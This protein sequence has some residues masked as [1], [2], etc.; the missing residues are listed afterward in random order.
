M[1][2]AMN[3]TRFCRTG[4]GRLL[5][6]SVAGTALAALW[7]GGLDTARAQSFINMDF[8]QAGESTI[9]SNA[10]WLDWNIGAPG[11]AHAGA[12]DSVF[13]YHYTPSTSV[14]QYYF[15]ADQYSTSWQPLNGNYSLVLLSGHYSPTD[16]TSPWINA[17]IAQTAMIPAGT[18]SFTMLATGNF[19]VSIGSTTLQM[20]NLGS[21][22][23]GAD[24][25]QFAGQTQT[26]RIM[27]T[28]QS[29]QS[30]VILDDL[31]F[32]SQPIPEPGSLSLICLGAGALVIGYLRRR[33]SRD[34]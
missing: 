27:N 7:A 11:W 32:S 19:S 13:V 16:S 4:L 10:V 33:D 26:L 15:L 9:L 21:N 30:P 2:G 28:S 34:A 24:V 5:C 3:Q 18:T 20:V 23:F 29:L 12:G 17:W 6:A 14:G 22:L 8:S 1:M 31:A 25:S